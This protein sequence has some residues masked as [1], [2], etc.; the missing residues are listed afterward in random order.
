MRTI[1]DVVKNGIR[2]VYLVGSLATGESTV[3]N[4]KTNVSDVD[5]IIDVDAV[6][7]LKFQLLGFRKRLST[8]LRL[9]L[10]SHVSPMIISSDLA[11]Y[12]ASVSPST[13]YMC[14]MTPVSFDEQKHAINAY[15]LQEAPSSSDSLNLA[16]SS[17]ADF[18]FLQAGLLGDMNNDEKTYLVAKRCLSLL[19]SF[20]ISMGLYSRS[21]RERMQLF[22]EN[23]TS[24]G[25]ILGDEDIEVLKILTDFKLSGENTVLG[26]LP[27]SK[28]QDILAFLNGYFKDLALRI[29]AFLLATQAKSN[30]A[31]QAQSE[32]TLC[33]LLNN[34]KIH[35]R[36]SIV[37]CFSYSFSQSFLFLKDRNNDKLKLALFSICSERL[38]AGASIRF[39]VGKAFVKSVFEKE[40]LGPDYVESIKLLWDQFMD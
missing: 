22:I 1:Q 5:I 17:I 38:K 6:T 21:Y 24:L 31:S 35:A 33:T 34:Y 10:K 16:F 7:F 20:L 37:S 2:Q 19:H 26:K 4:K 36:E 15:E 8:R 23:Y 13:L 18:L 29:F 39:L 32:L 28:G 40:S 12:F 9:V 3:L 11:R 25:A 27:T 14:E 30:L